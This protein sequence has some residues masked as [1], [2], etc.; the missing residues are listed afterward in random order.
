M[1]IKNSISNRLCTHLQQRVTT[2]L[3]NQLVLNKYSQNSTFLCAGITFWGILRTRVQQTLSKLHRPI[4]NPTS[5]ANCRTT[6]VYFERKQLIVASPL[7]QTATFQTWSARDWFT[8]AFLFGLRRGVWGLNPFGLFPRYPLCDIAS[9]KSGDGD[10]RVDFKEGNRMKLLVY[11]FW[12]P[13]SWRLA[14]YFQ[15]IHS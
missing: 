12:Y 14:L 11:G 5:G 2:L 7:P 3:K 6:P 10:F 8:L 15:Y 13:L 4:N 9:A 1:A